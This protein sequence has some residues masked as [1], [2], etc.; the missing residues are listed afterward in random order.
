MPISRINT[1][2]FPGGKRKALTLSYDDGVLQD[3]R[4]VE[5]MNRYGVKG[6]FNINTGLLGRREEMPVNG[7]MTDISTISLEEI[8]QLYQSHEV[9]THC[10]KHSALTGEGSAPLLELLEDR[11]VLESVVPYLV[12]G[13]AYPFGLYNQEVFGLLRAAGIRYA[14]TVHSTHSFSLPENF[15]EWNPTCHHKDE[16][17]MELLW[18]FCH[19]DAPFGQPQLFYLWGHAYEFDANDNWQ[20]MEDFL[21]YASKHRDLIWMATNREILQ[22]ITAY[23]SLEFTADGSRVY[24]PT[25]ETIWLEALGRVYEISSGETVKIKE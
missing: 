6:T 1:L 4:L 9:A 10:S 19:E 24:N 3:R 16:Q 20:V 18:Q 2:R 8:P 15:L 23:Q 11:R 17:L 21:A 13:H 12:W 7:R 5:L 22:Y 14:R 25:L